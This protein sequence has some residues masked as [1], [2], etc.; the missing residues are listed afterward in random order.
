M[1]KLVN[2]LLIA[3]LCFALLIVG[4]A[5]STKKTTPTAEIV[6][7]H[8]NDTHGRVAGNDSD[9]IGIDR[10][11]AI[12]QAT[13][14]S[15]L[16]DAGDTLHGL[17]IATLSK[18]ADI[19]T[20]MKA[21]GYDAMGIGNHEFNYGWEHLAMLRDV[22]GFPFLASNVLL[23][24]TPF[25]DDT[26]IIE[27]DSVSIGFFG[28]TTEATQY[29]AMPAFVEGLTFRNSVETAR[30]KVEYL[31]SKNVHVIV[32]LCHMGLE[33]VHDS[34]L[35]FVLAS[36]VPEIDII[37]DGHSHTELP[38]GRFVSG[39]LIAQTGQYGDN[40]GK[41][42]VS[43]EKGE[44][45]TK[46]ASLIT[47]DEAS[48]YIPDEVVAQMLS[49]ISDSIANM[50]DESVGESL[51]SMSS[52]RSPG[53]RTQEMPI[54]NLVADAYRS[55]SDADIAIAN[56]GDIRADIE[57][58]VITRGDIISVLPFGNT[59]MV[60]KIT[61]AVL[62]EV[63]ENGVSGIILDDENNIDY[64][65][66]PQGR[67]LQVSGFSFSYNPTAPEG[68]RIISVTLDTGYS[69]S[70][71]NTTDYLTIAGS[72]YVM[73]GGDYYDM[74]GTLP[75]LRELGSADEALEAYIRQ[76]S[77][78]SAAVEGRVVLLVD[79]FIAQAA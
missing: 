33:P 51:V 68:E 54:G 45:V 49:V 40:L 64:E 27:I 43:I 63:L 50:L 53:V 48:L 26:F 1:R 59:L 77:P 52:D 5:C 37:I 79:V 76:N 34:A 23:D 41:I 30:E 72:N 25:L 12:R 7:F 2:F 31:Q 58:G 42:T 3:A 78:V 69:L 11:A 38:E 66:S 36:E 32:A 60:K 15:I 56:G 47:Y 55:A 18:G 67:F 75:V 70:R 8:T 24:G 29:S 22:A 10:I 35:S 6:I 44:I 19:A 62:F 14:N 17:P 71:S 61:P 65:Q 4:S 20:L 28:I 39:V 21:A 74:L 73:T 9:I 57:A 13:P 16:V 46:A